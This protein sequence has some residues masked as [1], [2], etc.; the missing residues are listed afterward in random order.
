M[1]V[2]RCDLVCR[3]VACLLWLAVLPAFA[4]PPSGNDAVSLQALKA[5]GFA[6]QDA[7]ARRMLAMELVGCLAS[8]NPALRDG[9]AYE[10]LAKWMR[11]GE[12]DA[13]RLRDLRERLYAMLDGDPG[14]GFAHPFAALVLA[15]V[16]R[17][18]RV[19][20][21]M[22]ADERAVMVERAAAYVEGVRDYR[23]YDDAQ[24]WR[25]GV[26]HGADWLMQLALNPALDRAGADR[27]LAAVAV[28]AVPTSGHAYVSGEPE[29]LARPVLFVA[30]RGLHS[31][32]EWRAWFAALVPRIGDASLAYRDA[33]WLARR[34]DLLAFLSA[35]YIETDN[36]KDA[37]I[38]AIKPAVIAAL[39]T[40]P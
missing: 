35:V 16:A 1:R 25:H 14:E 39:R 21:W 20:P 7:A 19:A 40:M 5:N 9:I 22:P 11:A 12:L 6:L 30:Q 27:I 38:A 10:A 18:D 8:A 36:S 28:Q 3:G 34:H 24:G 32:E 26:A 29:R 23:G 31:N 15:E 4:C 17:T 2:S 33:G 13:A 37:E